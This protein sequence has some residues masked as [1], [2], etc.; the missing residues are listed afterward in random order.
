MKLHHFI[1]AII[2]ALS[3][4]SCATVFSGT[5]QTVQVNSNPPGAKVQVD[6]LDYGTTPTPVRLRRGMQGQTITI[7]SPG[8]A[9]KMF[10]PITNFNP[11]SV[12][13]LLNPL[14]WAIDFAT[15]A[16][17]R[18]DPRYYEVE[19]EPASEGTSTP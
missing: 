13:N 11:V 5:T 4:T 17:F 8:Y 18:Y 10:E 14:F 9:T 15:G 3:A 16:M 12:I 6:G 2:I 7:K 19:L 1:F